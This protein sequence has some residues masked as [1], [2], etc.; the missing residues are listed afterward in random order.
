[1]NQSFIFKCD[2]RNSHWIIITDEQQA[3]C[4]SKETKPS[5]NLWVYCLFNIRTF[6]FYLFPFHNLPCHSIAIK[7]FGKFSVN[8]PNFLYVLQQGNFI[9]AASI[10][11][12]LHFDFIVGL[13]LCEKQWALYVQSLKMRFRNHTHT[14]VLLFHALDSCVFIFVPVQSP[15]L[16]VLWGLCNALTLTDCEASAVRW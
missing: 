14:A 7:S 10:N 1:M 6:I 8:L 12:W 2:Q 15:Q 11:I 9:K 16:C 5:V 13:C 3:H 4:F